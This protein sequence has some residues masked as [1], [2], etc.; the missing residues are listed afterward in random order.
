MEVLLSI[1]KSSGVKKLS[2]S[3]KFKEDP[4]INVS[5]YL[6]TLLR[7]SFCGSARITP[8]KQIFKTFQ[9]KSIWL[10]E[11]QMFILYSAQKMTNNFCLPLTGFL[12]G[13][14]GSLHFY[15]DLGKIPICSKMP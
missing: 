10:N 5:I 9:V 3:R 14:V 6:Q 8:Q 11:P 7:D 15:G 2:W 13:D 4:V 1:D 12:V